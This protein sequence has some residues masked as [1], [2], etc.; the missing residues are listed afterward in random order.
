MELNNFIF[1]SL[2]LT[3]RALFIN[4]T[5]VLKNFSNKYKVGNL[6][7]ISNN[8]Y[9]KPFLHT[10]CVSYLGESITEAYEDNSLNS[11]VDFIYIEL[12][13][14]EPLPLKSLRDVFSELS[15]TVLIKS[16]YELKTDTFKYQ[17]LLFLK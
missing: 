7:L 6:L 13:V 14:N 12:D 15:T 2:K 16:P 3:N 1:Y 17:F 10:H 11:Y 4:N 5:E 8:K 9:E